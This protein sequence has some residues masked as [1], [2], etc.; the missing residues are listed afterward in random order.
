MSLFFF[1]TPPPLGK[2]SLGCMRKFFTFG[3]CEK[4]G[5]SP[6]VKNSF[7]QPKFR[8]PCTV[9]KRLLHRLLHPSLH[10]SHIE[11]TVSFFLL[12]SKSCGPLFAHICV[13]IPFLF[14]SGVFH[15]T[16]KSGLDFQ[17]FQVVNKNI[18]TKGN[19]I[20]PKFL[21]ENF[22]SIYFFPRMS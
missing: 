20:F 12:I 22:C 13:C 8:W 10:H 3:P 9:R 21:I 7:A 5:C 18:F 15:S 19:Q 4:W 16:R 2:Q 1:P 11:A 17:H 6:N 14:M